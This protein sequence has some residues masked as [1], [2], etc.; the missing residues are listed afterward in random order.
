MFARV[1]RRAARR[2][3]GLEPAGRARPAEARGPEPGTDSLPQIRHIVVLMMENHSYDN[4]FGMLAGR[5]DGF[6]LGPGGQPDGSNPDASGR[7]VPLR[8]A[9]QTVQ[10]RYVPTQSWNASHIQWAG[11]ACDGFVRSIEQTVP[12]GDAT[13]PMTYWT[14]ADLPFYYWLARTFPLATRWFSSCLG[15][16]FPN[17]RFLIS[18]TANGLTDDVLYGMIDHPPA[19]TILDHLEAHGISWVNYHQLTPLKVNWRVLAHARGLRYLRLL[20][21]AL[22]GIFTGALPWLESKVQTTADVYPLGI[23]RSL[24]HLR[25]LSAFLDAAKAGSLPSV[26]I[27]DPDFTLTSEENPQDIQVGEAFAAQVINAVLSSPAW[28][29]T[30]LIWLYDEHGGYYDHVPPPPAV[31]PDDEPA[32]GLYDKFPILRLFRNTALGRE[33]TAAD[34]G[35]TTYTQLGFRVPAVIVSPYAKPSYVTDVTFDHTAILKLIQRKWNLPPLTRR[36]AAA[37]D[38]LDALDLDGPGAFMRP[39]TPPAPGLKA[40]DGNGTGPG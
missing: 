14:E 7:A 25:P 32:R 24:N 13:I 3:L 6:P 5:G 12:G 8:H 4:Y 11:G 20:S 26:S 30:L 16:T 19:G 34:S 22:A 33:V 38:V 40:Q 29:D 31:A 9:P 39:P 2:R 17:R 35:P 10:V 36:D 18:G 21:G 15:P 23:L 28:P 27:V 37:A 1:E